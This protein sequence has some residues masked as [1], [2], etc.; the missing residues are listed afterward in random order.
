MEVGKLKSWIRMYGLKNIILRGIYSKF[1][2][3]PVNKNELLRHMNWQLRV[4]KR[5]KKYIMVTDENLKLEEENPYKN[6]IWFLWFQ[7]IENAPPIVQKCYKN[8]KR[9]AVEMGYRLVVLDKNNMNNYLNIPSNIVK[10]WKN[11]VIGNANFS[12]ICRVQLLAE[13]GGI[14]MDATVML[15]GLIDEEILQSELFF[16]Q[17]SFLDMSVTKISN[18]FIYSRRA[19]NAFLLSLRDSLYNYWEKNNII[20]DYFIFHLI[21]AELSNVEELKSDYEKIPYFSNTY[22]HLLGEK[23]NNIYDADQ[24]HKILK[25]S[26]IHKLT[27]KNLDEQHKNSFYYNLIQDNS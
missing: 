7:G 13:Y 25:K 21:V 16:F 11:G 17:A 12:D 27:Y 24:Y 20:D 6:V 22:P 8:A 1:L 3:I 4:K 26:N 15:T 10:K 5:L 9:Y 18:W 2:I 23:L 14:W 19:G